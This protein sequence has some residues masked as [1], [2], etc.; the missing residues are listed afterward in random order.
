MPPGYQFGPSADW[1]QELMKRGHHV[2]VYT[3]SREIDTPKTFCGESIRIRIASQRLS[4]CGRDL[5]AVERE[6]LK[7]MMAAD[8]C[9]LI[10]AHWT[11]QF[12][13]AALA[14]GLPTLIT[15]HDHPWKVL[16]YFRD[17]HR[18]ARLMMA[19]EVAWR[20]KHFTAVS[21]GAARHFQRYLKPG[22]EIAV[23]PNGLPDAVFALARE[24]LRNSRN[25]TVFATILQ[26]WSRQKNPKV[27]LKSFARVQREMRTAQ[28]LMF[29]VD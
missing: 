1:I 14:S 24:P 12:A 28:L 16:G 23:V 27:L 22:M 3:T 21:E 26:G 20:G 18:V 11:Y 13:L 15:I 29:G 19:Y 6:Q 7:Q 4:G 10:H 17:M 2:T 8:R 5:F 9:Q 25:T